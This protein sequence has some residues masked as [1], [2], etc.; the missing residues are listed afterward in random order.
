MVSRK[1]LVYGPGDR[2]T[3]GFLDRLLIRVLFLGRFSRSQVEREAIARWMAVVNS[4]AV[5]GFS[6]NPLTE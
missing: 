6:M 1:Y 5:A 4:L 3:Y 2:P